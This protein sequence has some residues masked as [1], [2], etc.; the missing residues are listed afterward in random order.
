MAE[1]LLPEKSVRSI[2]VSGKL[3]SNAKVDHATL[4]QLLSTPDPQKGRLLRHAEIAAR[5]G[6]SRER[7][8]QLAL[9]LFQQTG[10][11]RANLIKQGKMQQKL[12]HRQRIPQ[13]LLPLA[14]R[15]T[16][17]GLDVSH[18]PKSGA[19][20]LSV[21]GHSCKASIS[22]T[23]FKPYGPDGATY[24]RFNPLDRTASFTILWTPSESGIRLWI[25]PNEVANHLKMIYVP[26]DGYKNYRNVQPIINLEQFA[27]ALH[28]LER[29][30]P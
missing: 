17:A 16:D 21:N 1:K 11:D 7:I 28:L 3:P 5:L 25:L 19:K 10:V 23:I 14:K 2:K 8:R 18:D 29:K 27:N 22:R 24:H 13:E 4:K 15:L 12:Q 30:S 20:A 26:V 6:V 9:K